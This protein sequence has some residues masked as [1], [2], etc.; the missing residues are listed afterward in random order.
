MERFRS[1]HRLSW[2]ILYGCSTVCKPHAHETS[3]HSLQTGA[4]HAGQ[5]SMEGQIASAA[6]QI[7]TMRWRL[8]AA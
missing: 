8:K 3:Y 4:R 7:A 1:K 6:Q 5:T 2:A